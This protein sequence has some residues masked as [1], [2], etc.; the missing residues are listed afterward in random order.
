M[1]VKL[2]CLCLLLA[3]FSPSESKEGQCL[4]SASRCNE[5]IQSGPDCAWCLEDKYPHKHIRCDTP[6]VLKREGC[7]KQYNPQSGVQVTKNDSSSE[8]PNAKALFL[9]PQEVSLLLRPGVSQSFPLTITAPTEQPVTELT[10]DSSEVPA[11]VNITFSKITNGNPLVVQVNAEAARCPRKGEGSNQMQNRTGPWLVHI[12]PRG[13]SLS[14]KLEISLECQCDCE[15]TREEN[16]SSCSGHGALVCG[17]CQ[18]YE[19]YIGRQCQ[20]DVEALHLLGDD[21]CRAGPNDPVCS[22]R[23]EC[24]DGYCY[25]RRRENPAEK[26]SGQYCECSNFDCPRSNNRICGGHGRC[27]CGQCVCDKNWSGDDCSCTLETA[28]CTASN[29]MLC[30]GRGSCECG[31]CRCEES[32]MGM[33]CE[34]CPTCPNICVKYAHCVECRVFGTGPMKDRCEQACSH[35]TVRTVATKDELNNGEGNARL[36][37]MRSDDDDCFFFYTAVEL[38]SGAETSVAVTQVSYWKTEKNAAAAHYEMTSS[39]AM[40]TDSEGLPKIVSSGQIRILVVSLHALVKNSAPMF[41]SCYSKP[42]DSGSKRSSIAKLLLGVFV[43]YMLHTVWLLYAFLNTK[44]CDGGRGEHCIASYLEARPN[45]Q[46][47]VFTCLEPDNSHLSLALK[48]DPFDPH[49]TFE[50]Q[51]NVSLPQK[52]KD[53]GTLFAVVYVHRSGV[54]PLDD[55]REVHYAAQLTTYI[56]PSHSGGQ[57][58]TQER[59]RSESPVSHWRPLLPITMMSEAFTFSKAGVPSDVRRYMRVSQDGRQMVYLPLLLVNELSFRVRDLMEISSSTEQLPLTVSY[60]GISL[61]GFRFWVHLQD[62]VY[63]L[64]QF[65]FT[66]ENVDEIKEILVGS[67]L[68]LLVLTALIT[69]LQLICECLAL[70]NDI[71]SWRKKKSMV[72][73]SRKSVLW[74]SLSTLLIFLHLLEE[75]SLLVLLPVGLGACVEVWKLFKVFNIQMQWKSTK[76]HVKKLDE[77]ERKTV[78][79]DSQASRYLSYLVYPLCIS[80]AI[81][82][83]A[84]LR[85]KSYYAWLINSLVTGVYAFGFLSMA[86]Q[87]FINHKMK[88]VSHLQGTVLMYRGVN[89]LITDLC[90]CASFFSPSGNF[91]SSHQLSCFRDELLF[92]L[93]LYQRRHYAPKARRRDSGSHNKKVKTQ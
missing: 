75:T 19:R 4:M 54:S 42:G 70:K 46:L 40:L 82:S 2:T 20:V 32:Y 62:V 36:C 92:F 59:P 87:L 6:Q 65:G 33:T 11:E 21:N 23:G 77:E 3:L 85:Q 93:Y 76:L 22:N 30:S 90:T 57:G 13:F 78:E 37:K 80:G 45:L 47:S 68:Y 27:E 83:M 31:L 48:I 16:S 29:Q 15:R 8:P 58:G 71:S 35:V 63:S 43:V 56:S 5:C 26:Y 34:S 49:S 67:N 72:G 66:E 25:C 12:T 60:E 39:N 7:L 64:R 84:Y 14:V 38:P 9:Q 91:S 55:R 81:F 17:R 53:N 28:S 74:R 24:V 1:A 88:S 89:T 18:C 50:R 10:L 44:P 52:T 61:R 41:P 73:M 51:V 69:A 79:Y 86:P